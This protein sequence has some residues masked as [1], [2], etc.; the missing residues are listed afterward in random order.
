M[1]NKYRGDVTLELD[2]PRTLRI[3]GNAMVE[4]EEI[5][6]QPFDLTKIFELG[7]RGLRAL[8]FVGLKAED[9]ELTLE[10]VGGLFFLCDQARIMDAILNSVWGGHIPDEIK[11]RAE[12][13]A[14]NALRTVS[15]GESQNSSA[16]PSASV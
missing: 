1:E 2:R 16:Q 10:K 3:D 9:S 4:A 13:Q 7:A 14:K 8:L 11:D 5:L 6:G 12:E 15:L